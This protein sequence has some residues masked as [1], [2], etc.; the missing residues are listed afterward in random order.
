MQASLN[1]LKRES[2]AENREHGNESAG[3]IKGGEIY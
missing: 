1:W 2:T 3:P